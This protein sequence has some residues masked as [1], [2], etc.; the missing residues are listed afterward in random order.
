[1]D[2]CLAKGVKALVVVGPGFRRN[3]RRH[4][5]GAAARAG[6]PTRRARTAC[7]SSG[8]TRWAW[9]TRTPRSGS[10]P[11]WRRT[12]PVGGRV[13][14]FSQSGALGVTLLATAAERGLGLSTFVSA[15]N[16]ADLSGNDLLQYWQTD[17][18]TDV[19]LLYLESF[20]NPRKF[21]RLARRLGADQADRRGEERPVGERPPR[22]RAGSSMDDATVQALFEQ[23][24]VIRVQNVTQMFDT[25]LLLAHQPLPA[26][27]RVA[28]VGN[29]TALNTLV[30]DALH[31]EGPRAGRAAGRRRHDGEPGRPRAAAGAARQSDD[32][33]ALVV[34]FVPPLATSG[35]AH[36]G[37]TARGGRRI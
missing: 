4:G 11:R 26:G 15:G 16:R 24:G 9:R 13:G 20:G 14:F 12:C 34:V 28:V 17:A 36:A 5:D 33:D 35:A 18:V 31:D 25:A 6:S 1:M 10:T 27:S 21:A 2:S 19:V 8:R 22:V 37:R 23:S 30:V 3:G 32:V 7:A 29:S